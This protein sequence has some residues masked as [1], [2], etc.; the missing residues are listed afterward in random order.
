VF[1]Y[2]GRMPVFLLCRCSVYSSIMKTPRGWHSRG[3]LPHYDGG[4]IIQFITCRLYD[5]LPRKVLDGFRAELQENRVEDIDR[6]VMIL[7]EKFLDSGYGE[8]FLKQREVAEIVRD[9]LQKFDGE[10]Y[11]LIAWVIMPNHIHFL[12]KPLNDWELAKILQ[13][14]KS[15]TALEANK[16]LKRKGEFWMREYFDRYIRDLEHFE[17]AFRYIENN[18][19]K[20]GFCEKPEDW[21]FSSAYMRKMQK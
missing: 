15:F 2:F 11:K 14:F 21:E 19:V 6:K 13:S 8:C 5:S 17:K 18:P 10:R 12:F 20:A 16:V 7:V 1:L 9:A 4:S 3:F